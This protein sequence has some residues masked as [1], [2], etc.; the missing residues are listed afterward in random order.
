M[1][2]KPIQNEEFH[3][4]I[5]RAVKSSSAITKFLS[6]AAPNARSIL[7]C[8]EATQVLRK[9]STEWQCKSQTLLAGPDDA[10]DYLE[11]NLLL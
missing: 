6:V 11:E 4:S 9:R 2:R 10:S 5:M 8:R 3:D 7:D 1:F